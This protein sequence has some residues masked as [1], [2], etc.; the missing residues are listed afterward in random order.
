MSNDNLVYKIITYAAIFVAGYY[1]GGGC[2]E[3][4]A[5]AESSSQIER[6]LKGSDIKIAD[7]ERKINEVYK[8]RRQE[9]G[10]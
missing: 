9:N 3:K 8:E 6:I 10:K 7:L 5:R 2:E 4:K 1:L